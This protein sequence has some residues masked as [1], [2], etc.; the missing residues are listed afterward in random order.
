MS[1]ED[2]YKGFPTEKQAAYEDWLV[3]TYGEDLRGDVEASS[4]AYA[5]RSQ[6]EK[7]AA[8]AEL[9]EL[10]LGLAGSLV[11]GVP[12]GAEALDGLLSR[13][14][15][16][17]AA[18]WGRDCSPEAYVGLADLYGAHPDFRTRYETI[19]EG[20]TDYLTAAM[21]AYAARQQAG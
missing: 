6:A 7:D 5:A 13:H 16:W 14:R 1:N 12:P 8:M 21:K 20:L 9:R 17:V 3:A 2:L 4:K 18:M 15:A 10:E 19:A 11:H